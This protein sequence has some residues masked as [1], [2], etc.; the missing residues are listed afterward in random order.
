M[1]G[2]P[3]TNFRKIVQHLV[4]MQCFQLTA[5]KNILVNVK[6]VF[7]VCGTLASF[8]DATQTL[9]VFVTSC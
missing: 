6:T 8:V 1:K 7:Y 4:D 2:S 3:S 9:R 5:L